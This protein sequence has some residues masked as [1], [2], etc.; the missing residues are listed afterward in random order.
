MQFPASQDDGPG[1]IL[2]LTGTV[3]KGCQVVAAML[4]YT[5]R[6]PSQKKKKMEVLRQNG[7]FLNQDE[8]ND[9]LQLVLLN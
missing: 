6:S 8:E 4:G 9:L 7:L 2:A 1:V 3:T 5:A